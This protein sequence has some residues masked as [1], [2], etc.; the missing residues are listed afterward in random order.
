MTHALLPHRGQT[1]AYAR[2]IITRKPV[3]RA[4]Q[5]LTGIFAVPDTPSAVTSGIRLK[6]MHSSAKLQKPRLSLAPS[7]K[8]SAA[9]W[10]SRL[11]GGVHDGWQTAVQDAVQI[12]APFACTGLASAGSLLGLEV[13]GRRAAASANFV[14]MG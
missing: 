12:I 2:P 10:Q 6:R 14:A 1:T 5:R 3:G 9:R 13:A 11:L 7:T 8:V 4:R